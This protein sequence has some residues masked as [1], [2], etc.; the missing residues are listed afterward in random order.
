MKLWY[1]TF[2][3]KHPLRDYYVIVAASSYEN[4]RAAVFDVLGVKFSCIYP[5]LPEAKYVPKG[6]VGEMIQGE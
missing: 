5:E 1:V 3:A 4:A 2:G 6:P